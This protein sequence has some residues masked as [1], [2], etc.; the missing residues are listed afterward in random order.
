MP[1]LNEHHHWVRLKDQSFGFDEEDSL[2]KLPATGY[3]S[4]PTPWLNIS[5]V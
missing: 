2:Q 4:M 3:R 1:N 5:L